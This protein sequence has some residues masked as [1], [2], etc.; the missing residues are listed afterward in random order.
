MKSWLRRIRG[1]VGVGVT[2]AAGWGLFGGLFW[3]ARTWSEFGVDVAA[4]LGAQYAA[5]GFVGGLTFSAA[6]RLKEG[7]RRFDELSLPAFSAMGAL[8]GL[9]I[10]AG[11]MGA[12]TLL[13]LNQTPG[14]LAALVEFTGITT[15]LGAACAGGSLA[16]ARASEDQ[17]LLAAAR[18][19]AGVGLTAE[20]RGMLL[21]DTGPVSS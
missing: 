5:L 9:V 10:G 11:Y 18:D 2:W 16:V 17:D 13:G 12:L 6:L 8:G 3:L 19:S 15:A 1:A 14:I 7:R 20:E 4:S 21:D